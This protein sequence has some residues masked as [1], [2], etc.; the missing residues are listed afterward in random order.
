M[1]KPTETTAW[2]EQGDGSGGASNALRTPT[3]A[4]RWNFGWKT[5]PNNDPSEVGEAPNL[6]Q[7]NYWQYAVHKWLEW[8]NGVI[9]DDTL[10]EVDMWEWDLPDVEEIASNGN[11]LEIRIPGS[12]I[13]ASRTT[14]APGCESEFLA[15]GYWM[16]AIENFNRGIGFKVVDN[17]DVVWHVRPVA[18]SRDISWAELTLTGQAGVSNSDQNSILVIKP[19]AKIEI[20]KDGVPDANFSTFSDLTS[21]GNI[22]TKNP[23]GVRA[24]IYEAPTSVVLS[25]YSN[26]SLA[27]GARRRRYRAI[28]SPN[29]YFWNSAAF[30]TMTLKMKLE[31]DKLYE[32]TSHVSG[33]VAADTGIFFFNNYLITP[34]NVGSDAFIFN[35]LGLPVQSANY[36][37]PET[38]NY[39]T[40]PVRYQRTQ[41]SVPLGAESTNGILL[42]LA[43]SNIALD[44]WSAQ[45]DLSTLEANPA[46]QN[47]G[48][49]SYIMIEDL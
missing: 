19:T 46:R 7:Q 14:V 32:L 42:N 40:S 4:A 12:I 24:V 38:S 26:T 49:W 13:A 21:S 41:F 29:F 36:F 17:A 39:V 22:A 31:D 43:A 11:N 35:S 28:S 6:N 16:E 3:D 37:S 44:I 18:G 25:N 34:G 48:Q 27:T 2:A 20:F 5:L 47:R 8:F 33:E 30:D 15:I 10:Q 45:G 1:A 9:P 23:T